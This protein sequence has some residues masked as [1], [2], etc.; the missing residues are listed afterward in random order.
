MKPAPLLVVAALAGLLAGC[1]GG[2]ATNAPG[3]G[4][5]PAGY[6]TVNAQVLRPNSAARTYTGRASVGAD[7]TVRLFGIDPN[8][9]R[10]YLSRVP[11]Q[12]N[13][14]G[15]NA[16]ARLD[17]LA[18]TGELSLG[19]TNLVSFSGTAFSLTADGATT[20]LPTLGTGTTFTAGSYKGELVRIGADGTVVD[21]G[22]ASGL[23]TVTTPNTGPPVRTATVNLIS[24]AGS[25]GQIQ[26]TLATDGTA[27]STT[28]T[29][30]TWRSDGNSFSLRLT[31]GDWGTGGLYLVLTKQA[32]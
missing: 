25:N 9:S 8:N 27:T 24:T 10:V 11:G 30:G 23:L 7:G 18:S 32:P 1:G 2:D 29:A 6:Y 17:N 15:T 28:A 26:A 13:S 5:V 21:W 3:D 4:N 19:V 20:T 12:L 22:S 16:D 14:D 31:G